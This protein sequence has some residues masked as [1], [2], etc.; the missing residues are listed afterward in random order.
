MSCFD[1]DNSESVIIGIVVIP[2]IFNLSSM[3]ALS[4]KLDKT[5]FE[6]KD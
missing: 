2:V 6:Q 4:F 1:M 3:L 5:K